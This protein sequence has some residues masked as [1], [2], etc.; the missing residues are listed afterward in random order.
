MPTCT[1]PAIRRTPS[2]P[3]STAVSA[4]RCRTAPSTRHLLR[5][6]ARPVLQKANLLGL[7]SH[8]GSSDLRCFALRADVQR[9]VADLRA[10]DLNSS[11]LSMDGTGSVNLG[12]ET[13]A[14]RLR[15]QGRLAGTVIVVP[16]QVTGPIRSPDVKVN[17]IGAAESNVGTVAGAV[18]GTLTP[19]GLLG[20]LLGG[21]KLLDGGSRRIMCR[22]RWRSPA[23]RPRRQARAP[24]RRT[25]RRNPSRTAPGACCMTCS[26]KPLPRCARFSNLS[27][28]SG[29][30]R[31]ATAAR[32]RAIGSPRSTCCL[33]PDRP[34]PRCFA[35]STSPARSAGEVKSNP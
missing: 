9:G 6:H 33:P 26:A 13:L 23:V 8:G 17:A 11:V 15:P 3:G 22:A 27:R 25:P 24:P 34:H 12:D 29:R 10:L 7:L 30:G 14:L 16:L 2:P 32:V 20:G 19:L 21:G 18:V 5:A 35:P 4:W 31:D 28:G 1:A